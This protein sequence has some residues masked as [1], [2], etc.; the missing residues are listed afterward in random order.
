MLAKV[1]NSD[2]RRVS[3]YKWCAHRHRGNWYARRGVRIGGRVKGIKMHRFILK[4]TK[5]SLV[6]DHKDLDGLNNQRSNLRICTNGQNALNRRKQLGK[7]SSKYKGVSKRENS[8]NKWRATIN[9][10]GKRIR[11][12]TFTTDIEAAKA[13]D[14]AATRYHGEFAKLNF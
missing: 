8:D 12:G 11:L 10:C 6:V 14:T 9:V 2:Y 7:F 4:I 5:R 3:R 13:Y 1:D